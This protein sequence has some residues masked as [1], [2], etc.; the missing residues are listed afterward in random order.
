MIKF[1]KLHRCRKCHHIIW[2][3]QKK[4]YCIVYYDKYHNGSQFSKRTDY[5]HKRCYDEIKK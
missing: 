2:W 4:E 5:Y 1:F 3:W